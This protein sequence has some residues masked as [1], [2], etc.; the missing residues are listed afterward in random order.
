MEKKLLHQYLSYRSRLEGEEDKKV[1]KNVREIP[2]LNGRHNIIAKEGKFVIERALEDDAGN[3][4]CSIGNEE[5][6]TFNVYGL[7]ILL[8]Q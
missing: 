5:S 4:S 7:F 6:L 8:L 1:A 3:Y 2:Q